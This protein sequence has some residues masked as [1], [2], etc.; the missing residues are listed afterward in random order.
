MK[1]F[2]SLS[3]TQRTLSDMAAILHLAIRDK[4]ARTYKKFGIVH[5]RPAKAGEHIVTIVDGKQETTNTAHEGDYVVTGP[6]GEEYIVK[7]DVFARRYV[8][9]TKANTWVPVGSCIAIPW[10]GPSVTFTA[11]WGEAMT[12]NPGDML[13]ATPDGLDKPYRIEKNVFKETY[14]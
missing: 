13:A 6:K 9:G 2:V 14:K 8:K 7:G 3:N 1:I 10:V 11:S 5:A 4:S 12:I